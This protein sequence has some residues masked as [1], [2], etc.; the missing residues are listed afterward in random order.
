[1]ENEGTKTLLFEK[2]IKLSAYIKEIKVGRL[3]GL[4][5]FAQR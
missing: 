2:Q 5:F 3:G 1:L 4:C